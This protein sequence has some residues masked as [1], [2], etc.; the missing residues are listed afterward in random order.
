[1]TIANTKRHLVFAARSDY[2]A[3]AL[4]LMVL[5]FAY[6]RTLAPGLT[7]ASDGSDGGDLITA[8]ATFGVA[9]P[10]GYPTYLLLARLFQYLPTGDLALRTTLLSLF[11]ALCTALA[12]SLLVR[13]LAGGRSWH[14]AAAASGAALLFGL[15]PLFWSQAIIAEVYSLNALFA[16]LMLLFSLRDTQQG[17]A[18]GKTG[19]WQ[20]LLVGLALGNHTTIVLLAVAWLIVGGICAPPA[21]R[22]RLLALRLAGTAAGLLVYLYV[23]LCAAAHPPVNWGNASTWQGFWWL[24]SGEPYHGLAFGLP[25]PWLGNRLQAWAALLVQQFGWWGVALGFVGLLYGGGG[26]RVFRWLTVYAAA[27][28]SAFAIGYNTAD[29]Y[30]YLIPC[31]L[32]F[33]IWIGLGIEVLLRLAGRWSARAGP[34]VALALLLLFAL[35]LP[36]TA[37]QVDASRDMRAIRYANSVLQKLPARAI[38]LTTSDEDTFALWYYHYAL[39]MRPDIAVVVEPLLEFAWYRENTR[40]VYPLLQIPEQRGTAWAI[41][42]RW[43]NPKPGPICHTRLSGEPAFVCETQPAAA[44]GPR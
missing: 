35:R 10:T 23:P 42:L 34:V 32:V 40:L 39:G 31:Y 17:T 24:I 13:I 37:A 43:L 7:W 25:S 19:A 21:L 8:A 2:L 29:S 4:L 36:A 33:A 20:G 30:A 28:Y 27:S 6:S 14:R 11:S 15:S 9:H 44:D 26:W 1:M 18:A 22:W 5:A 3:S 38:V 16:A 12:V 41:S